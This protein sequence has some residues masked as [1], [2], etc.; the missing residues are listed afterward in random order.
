MCISYIYPSSFTDTVLPLSCTNLLKTGKGRRVSSC[1]YMIAVFYFWCVLALVK[2][3][4]SRQNQVL[5]RMIQ[6][7]NNFFQH[8]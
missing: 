4:D 1:S 5:A 2:G 3:E 7:T 6:G 8:H